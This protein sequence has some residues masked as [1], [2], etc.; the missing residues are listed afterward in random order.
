MPRKGQKQEEVPL[1][2][3]TQAT[4]YDKYTRFKDLTDKDVPYKVFWIQEESQTF[5]YA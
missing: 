5:W 2:M 4:M 1:Q 3:A